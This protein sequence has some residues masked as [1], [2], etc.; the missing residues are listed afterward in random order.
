MAKKNKKQVSKKVIAMSIFN[1][2]DE[3]LSEFQSQIGEKKFTSHLKRTAKSFAG[4]IAAASKKELEKLKKE[5]KKIAKKSAKKTPKKTASQ[6]K[7]PAKK[8]SLKKTID[9]LINPVTP[10]ISEPQSEMD[11]PAE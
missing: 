7:K 3:A 1:R 8:A 11:K 6:N 2:L 4:D 10:V 9:K 5:A